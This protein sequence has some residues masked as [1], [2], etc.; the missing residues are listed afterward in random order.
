[1]FSIEFKTDNAAFDGDADKQAE[2]ARILRGIADKVEAGADYGCVR[3]AN[4]N[5]IGE[6]FI[7]DDE[8]DQEDE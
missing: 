8:D 3:D 5:T 2:V 7:E 4:G 1:M 6:F